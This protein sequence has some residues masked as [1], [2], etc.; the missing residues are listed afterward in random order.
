MKPPSPTSTAGPLLGLL[1]WALLIAGACALSGCASM[2]NRYSAWLMCG[3]QWR[4]VAS[5][6]AAASRRV[7]AVSVTM[8]GLLRRR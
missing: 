8:S 1:L 6:H 5:E 2:P 4:A 3:T 7:S